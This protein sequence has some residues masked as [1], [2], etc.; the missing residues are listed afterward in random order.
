MRLPD[1][2]VVVAVYESLT[3]DQLH[4][5]REA[6]ELDLAHGAESDFTTGRLALIDRIL[7]TRSIESAGDVM[8]IATGR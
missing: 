1:D 8:D 7:A 3:T 5:M 6:F 2:P 4:Q